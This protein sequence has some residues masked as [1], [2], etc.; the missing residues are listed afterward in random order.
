MVIERG[1]DR[2]GV[3]GLDDVNSF[4]TEAARAWRWVAHKKHAASR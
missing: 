1:T 2:L 4:Y 3:T